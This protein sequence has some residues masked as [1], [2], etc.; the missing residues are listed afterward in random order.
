MKFYSLSHD[1]SG[2]RR[3]KKKVKGEVYAKYT[4]PPF[5]PIKT[6]AIPSYADI[7]MAEGRQYKSFESTGSKHDCSKIEPKR[8]TGDYVIGISTMHKSNA[9]PIINSEEAKEHSSMR[10]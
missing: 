7:R 3:K 4:P 1:Y 10:R 9:V 5:E 8:Y 2:R 6:A